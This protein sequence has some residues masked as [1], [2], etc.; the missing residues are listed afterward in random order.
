M[1]LRRATDRGS[2]ASACSSRPG[3]G[4]PGIGTRDE[5]PPAHRSIGNTRQRLRQISAAGQPLFSGYS[6]QQIRSCRR[7]PGYR[8]VAELVD[9]VRGAISSGDLA[10]I[11]ISGALLDVSGPRY[12]DV[13][14]YTPEANQRI[15][16]IAKRLGY[17]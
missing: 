10:M 4:I 7:A 11:D 17:R 1:A 14:H 6:T 2:H 12:L 5:N 8:Y 13:A 9:S 16:A 3:I 15:A